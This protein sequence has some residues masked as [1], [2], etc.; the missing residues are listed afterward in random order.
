MSPLADV[1]TTQSSS[2]LRKMLD[3]MI[4]AVTKYSFQALGGI[5]IVILGFVAAKMAARL[6][7]DQL[8]RYH[9]DVTVAKFIVQLVRLLV[10]GLSIL[11]ALGKFGIEIAPLIAG[12]S[13]VG[14]AA[15]FALQGPLSNYAS[16]ATLIFTKPFKVGDIIEV[17]GETGEVV[18]MT[19]PRTILKTVDKTIVIIP[20][21]HIIGEVIHNFSCDKL[22]NI[23]VSVAYKTDVDKAIALI[24]EVVKAEKR[25]SKSE[26]A[27]IGISDFGDSGI[28][29]Y[30]RIWCQQA[31]YWDVL[32]DVNKAILG[33]FRK[34]GIEIPFPQREV[35]VRQEK[36]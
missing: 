35:L 2:T 12:L 24:C 31:V 17:V 36:A 30:A 32:F 19:L 28:N 9:I 8:K 16:G 3:W 27:K 6:V 15:S 10:V 21:K 13:V 25:V 26:D 5:V 18:D 20:N 29:L 23:K 22:I 1:A 34:N 4:E 14:F 11:I 7:E 33:V